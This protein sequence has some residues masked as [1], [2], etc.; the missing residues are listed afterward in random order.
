[1]VCKKLWKSGKEGESF[2]LEIQAGGGGDLVLQEI[3][4]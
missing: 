3:Q 4:V 1:M 2:A